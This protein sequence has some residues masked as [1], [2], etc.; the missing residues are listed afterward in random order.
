[1]KIKTSEYYKTMITVGG[2]KL[3]STAQLNENF[4]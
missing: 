2:I 4:Y 3:N 1:M